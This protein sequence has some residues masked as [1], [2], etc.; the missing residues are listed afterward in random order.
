ME[1]NGRNRAEMKDKNQNFSPLSLQ[2]STRMISRRNL[3]GLLFNTLETKRRD[4]NKMG[5][6]SEI[7]NIWFPCS[8][9]I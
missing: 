7:I 1:F 4:S 5:L 3:D 8:L 9:F 6:E 2:S